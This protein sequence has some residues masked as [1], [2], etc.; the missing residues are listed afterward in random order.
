MYI[1]QIADKLKIDPRLV[2]FHLAVLLKEGFAQG[3]WKVTVEPH[4]KGKAA[5]FYSLTPKTFEVLKACDL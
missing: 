5:K 4:S 2:S 3:E 1:G